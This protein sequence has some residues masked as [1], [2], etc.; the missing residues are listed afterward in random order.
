MNNPTKEQ[1]E[2]TIRWLRIKQSEGI[3]S[4]NDIE[5]PIDWLMDLVIE[6]TK[7]EQ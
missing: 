2:M 3:V 1:I 5:I 4:V 7:N 6:Y